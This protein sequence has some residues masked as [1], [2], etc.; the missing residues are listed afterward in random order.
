MNIFVLTSLSA[1][2]I[3]SL[4]KITRRGRPGSGWE[5]RCL[6]YVLYCQ[7][8]NQKEYFQF[9]FP[10]MVTSTSR[11]YLSL[12]NTVGVTTEEYFCQLSE[13]RLHAAILKCTY[14]L[15]RLSLSHISGPLEYLFLLLFVGWSTFAHFSVDVWVFFFFN[16]YFIQPFCPFTHSGIF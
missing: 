16:I 12:D 1:S 6:K 5:S 2:V 7:T 4:G 13:W 15:M 3:T 10:L 11:L 8:V 14:L 9:T